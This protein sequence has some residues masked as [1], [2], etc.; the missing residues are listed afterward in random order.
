L[1]R[2]VVYKDVKRQSQ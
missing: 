1:T 2:S